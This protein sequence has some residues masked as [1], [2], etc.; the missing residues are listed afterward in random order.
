MMSNQETKTLRRLVEIL[1][2]TKV[3]GINPIVSDYDLSNDG[4]RRKRILKELIE[5]G[6]I[7]AQP[8]SSLF[9]VTDKAFEEYAVDNFIQKPDLIGLLKDSS[10]HLSDI[11]NGHGHNDCH[12][13]GIAFGGLPLEQKVYVAQ[14]LGEF[15]FRHFGFGKVTEFVPGE[16]DYTYGRNDVLCVSTEEYDEFVEVTRFDGRTVRA[17]NANVAWGLNALCNVSDEDAEL[18]FKSS[19]KVRIPRS[20]KND[21][22][23]QPTD[24]SARVKAGAEDALDEIASATR[25]HDAIN[26]VERAVASYGGWEKFEKDLKAK[27]VEGLKAEDTEEQASAEA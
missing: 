18:A 15:K 9:F 22:P 23:L 25:R 13:H 4:R 12:A 2:R 19:G 27:V 14:H 10:Y 24:C 11:A 3:T 8:D 6:L 1:A 17:F 7:E 5:E 20:F 26:R 21:S 16:L